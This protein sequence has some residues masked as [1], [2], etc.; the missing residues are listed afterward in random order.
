[1]LQFLARLFGFGNS[2][3]KLQ[4]L[5]EN[6]AALVDVR[7]PAEFASDK[8][9]GAINIPLGNLSEKLSLLNKSDNIIVFCRSGARSSMAKGVLE[10]NGYTNVTNG[11]GSSNVANAIENMG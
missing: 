11:G 10:K 2:H 8:V 1:M 6:G 4:S 7:S 9:K 3:E 5:I